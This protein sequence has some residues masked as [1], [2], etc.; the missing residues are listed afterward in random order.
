MTA[1]RPIAELAEKYTITRTDRGNYFL[2]GKRGA[3]YML[4][5]NVNHPEALFAA[6]FRGE[7]PHNLRDQWFT[8]R[9]FRVEG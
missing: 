6:S 8:D 1:L 2:T 4:M 5:R 7:L 3:T 9:D